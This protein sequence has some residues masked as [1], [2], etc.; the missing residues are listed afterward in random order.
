MRAAQE[1]RDQLSYDVWHVLG[2]LERTLADLPPDRSQLQPQLYN[3]LESLLAVAGIIAESMVRDASW[4]FLDGGTRIDLGFATGA[5]AG[6][7][8]VTVAGVT[9]LLESDLVLA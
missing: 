2:R 6:R 8:V 9:G 3:V 4:G 7:H 5:A 1:V